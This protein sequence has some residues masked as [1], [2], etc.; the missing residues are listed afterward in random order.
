MY[1]VR[2]VINSSN[3]CTLVYVYVIIN[4]VTTYFHVI[5]ILVSVGYIVITLSV[6]TSLQQISQPLHWREF[7][8]LTL[9]SSLASDIF[10]LIYKNL[11]E[12]YPIFL[13]FNTQ[14][15]V[16]WKRALKF[17]EV[18]AASF[19]EEK[20]Q[21]GKHRFYNQNCLFRSISYDSDAN[22]FL[23]IF[24]FF[25]NIYRINLYL[26]ASGQNGYEIGLC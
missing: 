11:C 1:V 13:N 16:K 3:K 7:I 2:H 21:M 12:T 18:F 20:S 17:L 8:A 26:I 6:C 22:L 14:F 4:N 10:S 23:L 25:E 15:L 19:F 9:S 24:F 5:Y